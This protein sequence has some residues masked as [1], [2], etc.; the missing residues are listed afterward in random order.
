MTEL[1]FTTAP[2]LAG[3]YNRNHVVD[4]ADYTVWRNTLGQ[5]GVSAHSGADGDGDGNVTATDYGVW[6]A[7]YGMTSTGLGSFSAAVPEPATPTLAFLT[8]LSVVGS[9]SLRPFRRLHSAGLQ[10]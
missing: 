9:G 8:F 1:E 4:A 7:N 6:K 10:R 3:D 2:F 5:M